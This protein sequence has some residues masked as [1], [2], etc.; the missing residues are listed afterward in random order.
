MAYVRLPALYTMEF[1]DFPGLHIA[2]R[3]F[4]GNAVV[5]LNEVGATVEQPMPAVGLFMDLVDSWDLKYA[6]GLSVPVT[7]KAFL[8]HD[9]E[10]IHGVLVAW[11]RDVLPAP[12]PGSA[13]AEPEQAEEEEQ[14]D[15]D[16]VDLS[17]FEQYVLNAVPV[18]A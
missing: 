17:P 7:L 5:E 16:G 4:T 9:L 6:D 18:P 14:S 8:G 2:V 11:I 13:G 12:Y 1:A 15:S 3:G 10:F